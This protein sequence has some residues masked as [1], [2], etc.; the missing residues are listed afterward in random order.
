MSNESNLGMSL[1]CIGIQ[2]ESDQEC[3]EYLVSWENISVCQIDSDDSSQT[4]CTQ[5]EN[6]LICDRIKEPP[7]DK[8]TLQIIPSKRRT[9]GDG[10]WHGIGSTVNCGISLTASDTQVWAVSTV[11]ASS[12]V[13][14]GARTPMEQP[15]QGRAF[16][17]D[18]FAQS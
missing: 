7:T 13:T 9:I 8:N 4:A 5:F 1:T 14:S 12:M 16:H 3:P 2:F 17:R 15:E 6:H 10:P 11:T 18:L